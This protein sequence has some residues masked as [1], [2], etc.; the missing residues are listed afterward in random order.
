[1][2]NLT[3]IASKDTFLDE[4]HNSGSGTRH[5]VD[6]INFRTGGALE[7]NPVLEF[8]LSALA[9]KTW[10][11]AKLKLTYWANCTDPSPGALI[12]LAHLT[13]PVAI[14]DCSWNEY[15]KQGGGELEDTGLAWD[16]PGGESA[17]DHGAK[18]RVGWPLLTGT[19]LEDDVVWSPDISIPVRLGLDYTGTGLFYLFMYG[20]GL[21]SSVQQFKSLETAAVPDA[22]KPQLL[23]TDVRDTEHGGPEGWIYEGLPKARFGPYT[24]RRRP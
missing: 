20:V 17:G 18:T 23:F 4:N 14:H 1:M 7:H 12:K 10:T 6:H 16:L 21:N 15:D 19:H 22:D 5:A 24:S 2:A 13:Q 9:G 3:V 11:D 8:D